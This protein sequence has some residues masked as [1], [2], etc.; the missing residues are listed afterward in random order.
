[1]GIEY[2]CLRGIEDL[3]KAIATNPLL[4]FGPPPAPDPRVEFYDL[5]EVIRIVQTSEEPFSALYAVFYG[6]GIEQSC[7]LDLRRRDVT[8]TTREI[9]ARG[10]KTHNRD[11]MVTLARNGPCP[12]SNGPVLTSCL[13]RH[14]FRDST[15]GPWPST[16]AVA[17]R[18]GLRVLRV[19]E[20]R[21]HW[22]VRMIRAGTPIEIVARQ[23]GHANAVMALKV[24]GRF[25]PTREE[26]QAWEER[27]GKQ[28]M[29]R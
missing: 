3:E 25:V 8:L 1:M 19:H 26:R 11:R 14:C 22:A 10:T 15:D 27:A 2:E 29:K 7:A 18:L 4:G 12:T 6:A 13:T 24:Y 9:R 5:D 21:D 20:A 28:E 17:T 23:L 16:K